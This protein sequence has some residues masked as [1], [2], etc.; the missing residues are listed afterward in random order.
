[1]SMEK[2]YLLIDTCIWKRL[3]SKNGINEN[4]LQIRFW[5]EKG[6]VKLLCPEI[7]KVEWEKHAKIEIE[8]I[9]H[10]IEEQKKSLKL[11]LNDP[12]NI[13]KL[14]NEQSIKE[15]LESQIHIVNELLFNYA[16]YIEETHSV[17]KL[18]LDHQRNNKAPFKK[19]RTSLNDASIIFSSLEYINSHSDSKLIYFIS[20]NTND[21]AKEVNNTYEIDP[22][23]LNSFKLCDVK[24]F[25]KSF[26]LIN[27]LKEKKF[28][29]KPASISA[30][31]E[32]LSPNIY[33]EI[34][35]DQ[36]I[37]DQLYQFLKIRFSE[38]V[39]LPTKFWAEGYP[40]K[41]GI[42]PYFT[43][44]T[45]CLYTDNKEIYQLL[46]SVNI[47]NINEL[48]F[49]DKSFIENVDNYEEKM[50]FILDTLNKNLVFEINEFGKDKRKNIR[51]NKRPDC[52]CA[53]C[54]YNKLRFDKVF[55]KIADSIDKNS[56]DLSETL[57]YIHYQCGSY[58]KAAK[59]FLQIFEPVKNDG[60]SLQQFIAKYNLSRLEVF[61]KNRYYG[62]NYDDKLVENLENIRTNFEY[63][64]IKRGIDEKL[65]KWIKET[66][67]FRNYQLEIISDAIKVRD[68]YYSQLY[69]GRSSN[70]LIWLVYNNYALLDAIINNNNIIYDYYTEF[71]QLSEVFI[72]TILTSYAIHQSMYSRLETFDDYVIRVFIF[73]GKPDLIIKY[74]NR[75]AISSIKY[76]NTSIS[77]DGFMD[78][79]RNFLSYNEEVN[80]FCKDSDWKENYDFH[81]KYNRIFGNLLV[82]AS[83][84]QL[85]DEENEEIAILLRNFLAIPVIIQYR[86]EAK[87]VNQF[88]QRKCN[89]LNL[90]ILK[91]YFNLGLQNSYFHDEEYFSTILM[92]FESKNEKIKLTEGHLKQIS[93]L[94][95]NECNLCGYQH[96]NS[97]L[98]LFYKIAKNDEAKEYIKE[99]IVKILD[100][101][102][103][104]RLFYQ[105]S[106]YDVI[107]I[108]NEYF[109]K[110]IN[111]TKP[112][113]VKHPFS[114]YSKDEANRDHRLG[115]IINLCFKYHVDFPAGS[116]MKKI[117]GCNCSIDKTTQI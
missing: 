44:N 45:F 89:Q 80:K 79:I 5:V 21:F 49:T 70:N 110:L 1:M 104:W 63:E 58:M 75:Y 113:F 99:K 72:E 95:I 12:E 88:I 102:Y 53:K 32:S 86:Q 84:L 101:K 57:A 22:E 19:N 87:Y 26:S 66:H 7:L 4:L 98:G 16:I 61:A 48:E 34:N 111:I 67:F 35:R 18:I 85:S 81:D 90:N 25:I 92:C 29:E 43:Y 38:I 77:N 78:L 51:Y 64:Y 91:D 115:A 47:L 105:S 65:L 96:D 46:D 55:E 40:F 28:P 74:C 97:I 17:A 54:C 24:L 10:A 3:V 2:I 8:R 11:F 9:C 56:I 39:T 114:S 76:T 37:L 23:I 69:G 68:Y 93:R 116:A 6:Y 107:G 13:P 62:D 112:G 15:E 103:D 27:F 82:L 73:Y 83:Y 109:E 50:E 52:D 100:A 41:I 30:I 36:K 71:R 42:K 14:V 60:Y 59:L 33:Q 31:R 20:S 117:K 108:D 94:F 106:M